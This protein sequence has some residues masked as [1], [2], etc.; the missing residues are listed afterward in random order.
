MRTKFDTAATREEIPH[1]MAKFVAWT[2]HENP[3]DTPPSQLGKI[4]ERD[5]DELNDKDVI[6]A[7]KATLKTIGGGKPVPAG[8]LIKALSEAVDAEV[9]RVAGKPGTDDAKT[10]EI[11][12]VREIDE[13][14]RPLA[15]KALA[16]GHS[17]HFGSFADCS[18][19][20]DK[21][22]AAAMG[23]E[24]PTLAPD[25]LAIVNGWLAH[26]DAEMASYNPPEDQKIKS[27][28]VPK[29]PISKM[30]NSLR[31]QGGS[32]YKT[33]VYHDPA[34]D[35]FAVFAGSTN[36]PNTEHLVLFK[37][38]GAKVAEIR[39]GDDGTV[40]CEPDFPER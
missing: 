20:Y 24:Y 2:K 33:T 7:I 6:P 19:E 28:D 22:Y 29:G 37:R 16:Y 11:K 13:T 18:R 32:S 9:V 23:L 5:V 34:S 40:D 1:Q 17:D 14:F 8:K 35:T 27:R 26:H 12:E 15:L 31:A 4:T 36:G 3:R 21:V 38:D 39:L 25:A 10:L 30:M